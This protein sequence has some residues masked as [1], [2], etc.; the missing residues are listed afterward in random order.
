MNWVNTGSCQKSEA[1]CDQLCDEVFRLP[2]FSLEN[3]V[4]MNVQRKNQRLDNLSTVFSK[5]E[6]NSE[7]VDVSINFAIPTEQEDQEKSHT[8]TVPDF[9]YQPLLATIID[10]LK[11]PIGDKFYFFSFHKFRKLASGAFEQV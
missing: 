7:W 2:D 6:G 10:T 5:C 3:F 4:G 1:E 11:S 9:C 8:F